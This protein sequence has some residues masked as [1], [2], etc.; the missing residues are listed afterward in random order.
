MI[1][2]ELQKL[3]G[4]T[5]LTSQ[6]MLYVMNL[7]MSGSLQDIEIEE[8]LIAMNEKGAS[9][10]EISSA[11]SVMRDRSLK[12]DIG[13]GSHIDTCGTGGTGLH[14]FNCST[15]SAFVAAACGAKVTKHGNKSVSSKTG[16]ADFLIEAG[17][18]ISHDRNLLDSI[19][20]KTGFI[21][22]FAPLH[23]SSMQYVM[24]A[25]QKI[26]K[27]T[28]F[29]L[30][31][32]HTNPCSAKKQLIGVYKR[33]LVETFSSVARELEMQHVIV[34]HGNDGLDELSIT[35]D[36]YVSELKDGNIKNYQMSPKD[37]GLNYGKFES[38]KASSP[39]ESFE[40]ISLAF[41]GKEGSVQDM[42]A[43]NSAAAL[44]LSGIVKSMKDGVELSK[45]VMNEGLA[46]S[47]LESYVK[48]SKNL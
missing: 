35:D 46:Q 44:K 22:L 23:H 40:K 10:N 6:E 34:V 3:Q 1:E 33:S 31:G 9:I 12:F 28:I 16:S 24:P 29:N 14:I 21:F 15:A 27:K 41:S 30:L 38:I 17:A 7:I 13:D 5:D 37:Y 45:S 8:F 26:G 36:S 11:A 4:K 48:M 2:K 43:F 32:P 47:K 18:D 39:Q 25:R 19:F 20:E 42:I